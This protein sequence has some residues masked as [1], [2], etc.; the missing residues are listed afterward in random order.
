MGI[1]LTA[2][3]SDGISLKFLK[4]LLPFLHVF[5]HAITCSFFPTMWKSFIVRPVAKVAS[6]SFPSDFRPITIVSVLS[7]G[8]E[9]LINGQVL[10]HI[11]RSGLF[12][13]FPV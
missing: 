12:S 10:A 13:V 8:F 9:R 11:Y 6:S 3:S 7:K 1:T 5:N 4:L 2:I